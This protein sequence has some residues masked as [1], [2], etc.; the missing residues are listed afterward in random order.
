MQWRQGAQSV[1]RGEPGLSTEEN[2]EAIAALLVEEIALQACSASTSSAC[3]RESAAGLDSAVVVDAAKEH[4]QQG[5]NVTQVVGIHWDV[6]L[7][8]WEA[9]IAS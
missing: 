2:S 8:L 3:H 5:S 6:V 1:N 9:G 7:R 4:Q